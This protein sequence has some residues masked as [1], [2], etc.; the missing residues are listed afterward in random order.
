MSKQL[1]SKIASIFN[2]K[3][4]LLSP[5][6]VP[7]MAE[8]FKLFA[9]L[10]GDDEANNQLEAR[11][12]MMATYGYSE[13]GTDKPFAY[14]DGMAFIPITGLLINRYRWSWSFLTGYNAI[15]EQLQAA[16][17]DSDVKGIVFDVNSGGGQVVGCF[18]LATDIR[19]SR[20]IKP[21]VAVV[22][23]FSY[24]AAYAL[25]SSASRVVVTPSGEVGSIGA[26]ITHFDYSKMMDEVGVKVSLIHS[27]SHKVDGNPY[28]KLSRE[29]VAMFQKSVDEK[30]KEFVDLVALN[31]S[32]DTQVVYDTEA[33]SFTAEEALALGLVDAIEPPTQAVTA[34][35]NELS[36]SATNSEIFMSTKTEV[37]TGQ[38]A[39]QN[40]AEN[41]TPATTTQAAAVDVSAQ[42]AEAIVAERARISGITTCAE[43]ANKAALAN[44]LALNTQLSVEQAKA[45]L[46]AAA[47]EVA[48][49]NPA[50]EANAL[51]TAMGLTGG[52]A[53]VK[54]DEENTGTQATKSRAEEILGA[55]AQATG[56]SLK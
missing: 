26:L 52:G 46:A 42:V 6:Y 34:F 19:E 3:L 31:R 38:A 4:S 12:E 51:E 17:D 10:S 2:G 49:A 30:R 24:S 16:L 53:G 35:F 9:T 15:R 41:P 5:T 1:E 20:A 7:R 13:Y 36:S 27:G 54:A 14:A 56:K 8:D 40:E 55:Q 23:A 21:S 39:A 18:E 45:A 43:A 44:H 29:D 28:E 50:A 48:A 47:P 11:N 25:A 33:A 32:L 37:T 22:D